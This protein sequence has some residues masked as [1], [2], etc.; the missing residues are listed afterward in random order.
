MISEP[1]W[2][3]LPNSLPVVGRDLAERLI[4]ERQLEQ[5]GRDRCWPSPASGRDVGPE[6]H[7][8]YVRALFGVLNAGG[9]LAAVLVCGWCGQGRRTVPFR[10]L[11]DAGIATTDLPLLADHRRDYCERCGA[12]GAQLHHMAP[13]AVFEDADDWPLA[14]LCQACHAEWHRRMQVAA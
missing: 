10:L 6:P 2:R 3:R 4:R 14:Y 11:A 13:Q 1:E 9:T 5:A 8:S 7:H 12:L